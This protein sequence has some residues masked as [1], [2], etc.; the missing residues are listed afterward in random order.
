MRQ[1]SQVRS[2]KSSEDALSLLSLWK[3]SSAYRDVHISI[4]RLSGGEGLGYGNVERWAVNIAC[5]L[6]AG[7]HTRA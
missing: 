6:L 3:L 2:M 1:V 7:M 5:P 4:A